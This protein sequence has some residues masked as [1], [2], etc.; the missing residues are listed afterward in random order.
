MSRRKISKSAARKL[1]D[2][3]IKIIARERGLY[4]HCM[5]DCEGWSWEIIHSVY[6]NYPVDKY[7]VDLNEHFERTSNETK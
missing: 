5:P 4:W 7:F 1:Y 6:T 3:G 2:K